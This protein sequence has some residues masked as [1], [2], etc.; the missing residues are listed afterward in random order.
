MRFFPLVLT[1]LF[2]SFVLN[3]QRSNF[4]YIQSEPARLFSVIIN[5]DT[6]T[7]SKAGYLI[8]SKLTDTVYQ[9]SIRFPGQDWPTQY[10]TL[11]VNKA[12]HGYLLKDFGDKGW[13]L[14]DWRSLVVQFS[15]KKVEQQYTQTSMLT[16]QDEFSNLLALAAGDPS[17]RAREEKKS[18]DI[19]KV[20]EEKKVIDTI[21]KTIVP[22]V[23]VIKERLDTPLV[24]ITA[25]STITNPRCS[26][27]AT[28]EEVDQLL[29]SIAAATSDIKRVLLIS[30]ELQKF[31][32]SVPQIAALAGKFTTDEGR[33][34][35]LLEAWLYVSDRSQ[36]DSLFN[37]FR[38]PEFAVRLKEMLQ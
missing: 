36:F 28:Q 3:A 29:V 17:L 27:I 22:Q 14:M 26:S 15:Q 38:N 9:I 21:A 13:G 23:S 30:K 19:V 24:Q 7:S 33:Y 5:A 20:T 37:V 12:D 11:S 32:L 16:E 34:D 35:F 25:S 8:L 10:F 1:I 18:A 31:C 4:V 6:L 2:S